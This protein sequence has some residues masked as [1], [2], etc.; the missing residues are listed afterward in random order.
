M[1]TLYRT[2]ASPVG[3]R[4]L[5]YARPTARRVRIC[6][7]KRV[8][9]D[10]G[11]QQQRCE[12]LPRGMRALAVLPVAAARG[13]REAA[14]SGKRAPAKKRAHGGPEFSFDGVD[15][16]AVEFLVRTGVRPAE[17]A[18]ARLLEA[19]RWLAAQ[20]AD[21]WAGAAPSQGLLRF[22]QVRDCVRLL[23]NAGV[24][25]KRLPRSL[26]AFPGVLALPVEE[27]DERLDALDALGLERAPV[28]PTYLPGRLGRAL[29]RAP[30]L[31]AM[32]PPAAAAAAAA[33]TAL[34][35]DDVAALAAAEPEVLCEPLE[36]LAARARELSVLTGLQPPA[37]GALTTR[38]PQLLAPLVGGTLGE[39]AEFWAAA[40]VSGPALAALVEAAPAALCAS[41][42]RNL[43]PKAAFAAEVLGLD[44]AAAAARCPALFGAVNLE[45]TLRP[46]AAFLRHLGVSPDAVADALADWA[47]G[48]ADDFAAVA[49][50]LAPA[51]ADATA[52]SFRVHAGLDARGGDEADGEEDA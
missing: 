49:A 28:P 39:R 11:E 47:A 4:A 1:Y 24:D 52:A 50:R 48:S 35:V 42:Q 16:G 30:A 10:V 44:A 38:H 46:R 18:A 25:K 27:L 45:R 8:S 26:T 6:S 17:R 7:H 13:S 2:L 51:S 9:G 33:L 14:P 5:R 19:Q 41:V 20:E 31:L 40:G 15:A 43:R 37:L 36:A 23:V 12:R 3:S 32:S 21:G 22:P 34:G 29:E